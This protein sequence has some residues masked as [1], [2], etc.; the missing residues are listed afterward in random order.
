MKFECKKEAG[1][2]KGVGEE[3]ENTWGELVTRLGFHQ[4]KVVYN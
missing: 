1:G 2:G 4:G 3:R